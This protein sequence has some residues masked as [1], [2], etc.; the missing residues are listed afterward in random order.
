[1]TFDIS[2]LSSVRLLRLLRICFSYEPRISCMIVCIYSRKKII[3]SH[4][5]SLIGVPGI[6]VIKEKI[7]IKIERLDRQLI[8]ENHTIYH[9]TIFKQWT[10]WPYGIYRADIYRSSTLTKSKVIWLAHNCI[11]PDLKKKKKSDVTKLCWHWRS[12]HIREIVIKKNWSSVNAARHTYAE[13]TK[14]KN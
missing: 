14:D 2:L 13:T 5:H 4:W 1:M 12:A 6:K 9:K 10:P 3:L 8:R 7:K 11:R